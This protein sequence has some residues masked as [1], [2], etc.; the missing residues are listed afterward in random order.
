MYLTSN[1]EIDKQKKHGIFD[2]FGGANPVW[3]VVSIKSP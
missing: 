2:S 3:A 1:Q